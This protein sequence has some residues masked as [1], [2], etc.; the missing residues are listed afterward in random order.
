M[1]VLSSTFSEILV[2]WYMTCDSFTE[3]KFD[4]KYVNTL[5]STTQ[6]EHASKTYRMFGTKRSKINRLQKTVEYKTNEQSKKYLIEIWKQK[7][8]ECLNI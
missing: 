1:I 2:T 6:Q 3:S 5:K 8:V 7:A 4:V